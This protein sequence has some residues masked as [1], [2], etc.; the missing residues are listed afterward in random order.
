MVPRIEFTLVAYRS[1]AREVL[2]V[3][4][5]QTVHVADRYGSGVLCL[6]ELKQACGTKREVAQCMELI[7]CSF[8][9]AE[10][11]NRTEIYK[12]L[13]FLVRSRTFSTCLS[14]IMGRLT[15][16]I[17]SEKCVVRRFRRCANVI[18]FT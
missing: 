12:P 3:R 16:G 1:S 8:V 7:I 9:S 4:R 6:A 14:K 15:T 2:A 18:E 10:D 13:I 5:Q 17:R 11:K